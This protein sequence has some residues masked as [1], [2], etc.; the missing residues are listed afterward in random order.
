M[1]AIADWR[2][3]KPADTVVVDT[4]TTEEGSQ[5][6]PVGSQA[7]EKWILPL[8][9]EQWPGSIPTTDESQHVPAGTR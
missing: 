8:H 9:M 7:A 4:Q 1:A 3:A 5:P 2:Q 6:M